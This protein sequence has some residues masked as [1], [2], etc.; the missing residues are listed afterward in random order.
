VRQRQDDETGGGRLTVLRVLLLTMEVLGRAV[1]F[2]APDITA[3]PGPSRTL[4]LNLRGFGQY[5]YSTPSRS[6][7]GVVCNALLSATMLFNATLRSPR[8]TDPM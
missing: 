3:V 7:L 5:Y 1:A 6:A 8:S 2:A 4:A